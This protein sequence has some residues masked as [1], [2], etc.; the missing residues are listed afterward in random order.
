[1]KWSGPRGRPY[2]AFYL[3]CGID[4]FV[5]RNSFLWFIMGDSRLSTC[6]RA[7][8]DATLD[9]YGVARIW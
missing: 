1:M 7:A 8:I 4:F 6:A 3:G 5:G 2:S 9:L